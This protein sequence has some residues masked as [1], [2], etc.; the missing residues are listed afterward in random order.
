M[1][2]LINKI[3][4]YTK[5]AFLLIAFSITLYI[6]LIRMDSIGLNTWSIFPLFIPLLLILIL[7]VFGY[8]LN[9]GKDN[10]Y[11]NIICVL[12]LL[13]IILIDC[14]V[15]FDKN[16]IS[17]MPINLN[18]FDLQVGKIKIM[19]YLMLISNILLIIYEKRKKIHS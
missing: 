2:K 5:I 10:I 6:L 7:F 9:I 17:R 16:I 4:F 14:R 3:C 18:F 13:A 8:F 1:V 15:V 12:T 11:F 19:L